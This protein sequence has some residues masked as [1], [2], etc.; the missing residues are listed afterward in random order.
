MSLEEGVRAYLAA[1]ESLGRDSVRTH[2]M[3]WLQRF[4][5]FCQ[6]RE[7]RNVNELSARLV[8]DFCQHLTWTPGPTGVMYS[9][10]TIFQCQRFVRAFVAWLYAEEMLLEDLAKGWI[11]RRPPQVA[12]N[13]PTVEEVARLMQASSCRN[14]YT[15]Y[16]NRAV[17]ELLYGTGIRRMECHGLDLESFDLEN[18]RLHV[19]GKFGKDR[20]LPVGGHLR[21]VLR[22]YLEVRDHFGPAESE[23]ALLV[24]QLGG[25]LS[26]M[27][28]HQTVNRAA[29]RAGL[30]VFGPQT[31]RHAFAVHLLEAGAEL[32]YIQA[33]LGH[34]NLETTEIYTQVRP[35]ELKRE[36]RR[37]HPRALRKPSS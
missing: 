13:I 25:R 15:S 22:R 8:A 3:T 31:L 19:R 5:G 37:T 11:L 36:H 27:S 18:S 7:V 10:N 26:I 34:E 21:Q 14:R 23:R 16:R 2:S 24:N 12:R 35:L 4:L 1:L 30:A 20:I 33:L 28:I 32:T 29:K 9:Q 17:L 6:E